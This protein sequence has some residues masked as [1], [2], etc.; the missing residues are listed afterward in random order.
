[1]SGERSSKDPV[2]YGDFMSFRIEVEKRLTAAESRMEA[3]KEDI[4]DLKRAIADL[5]N[6]LDRVKQD[7]ESYKKY[8]VLSLLGGTI[9]VGILTY[10]LR[11]MLGG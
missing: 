4:G 8:I 2:N 1:M 5:S 9:L 7:I 6:K 11:L 3:M 10:I